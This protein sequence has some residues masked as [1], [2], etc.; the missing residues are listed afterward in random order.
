MFCIINSIFRSVIWLN[1][2]PWVQLEQLQ[3][4]KGAGALA[5]SNPWLYYLAAQLQRIARAMPMEPVA[6]R[7]RVDS[8]TA[9]G[10]HVTEVNDVAMGLEAIYYAKCNKRFPTYVLMQKVWNKT[11]QLLAVTGFTSYIPIWPN[12]YY[13]ELQLFINGKLY[14]VFDLQVNSIYHT[15]CA[16]IIYSYNMLLKHN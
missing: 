2:P 8:I 14:P 15:Q 1:G 11:R 9:L 12:G 5:L 13:S 16:S 4:P 6:V 7:R 10:G 3:K